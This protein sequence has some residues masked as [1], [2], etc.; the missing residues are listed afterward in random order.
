LTA[1]SAL[2]LALH[3]ENARRV[4]GQNDQQVMIFNF[5]YV[6]LINAEKNQQTHRGLT[7]YFVT[8]MRCSAIA[9]SV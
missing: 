7:N 4:L 8:S 2:K 1:G 6:E 5:S 3:F 9:Q